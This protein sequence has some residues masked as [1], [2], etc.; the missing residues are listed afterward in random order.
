M[1]GIVGFRDPS[2]KT[3]YSI[4]TAM[5]DTLTHRGPDDAGNYI[6]RSNS[7]GL[8][9]RRLSVIDLTE[10]GR[11]PMSSRDGAVWITY[12]GEIYNYMELRSELSGKGYKF[13]SSSDTE[14]LLNA[15]L[16]WGVKCVDKLIG[17]FA[18]AVWDSRE[19]A[20]YIFR[21][22]AGVKPL[23]YYLNDGLFLFASEMKA[24]M[25]HPDFRKELDTGALSTYLRYGYIRS[26]WTI[27]ENTYK[28]SP[29]HYMRYC[30][31][32]VT[33][34]KY[35]DILDY[36]T[37]SPVNADEEEIISELETLLADSFEYRLV[38]D[39][40]VG[41]FL[42]GGIDSSLLAALLQEKTNRQQKTYTIGFYEDKY[43]EAGWARR[44][45]EHLETDH[46]EY[47]MSVNECSTIVERLPE[48]YDEP[49]ADNSGIP[50][51]FVSKLA[52]RDVKVVLS[53]DGGDEL[54]GGY[55][56]YRRV[57][58]FH[59]T[60]S[61]FPGPAQKLINLFFSYFHPEVASTLIPI[62]DAFRDKYRKFR[63]MLKASGRDSMED[64]YRFKIKKWL[65]DE[66]DDLLGKAYNRPDDTFDSLEKLCNC[67]S[68]TKMMAA[69]FKYWLPGDILAKV[70]RAT[71][72]VGLE[73]REPFLDHR[74][75]QFAAALPNRLKCGN[76]SGKYVLRKILDKYVP[77]ELM[78]RPKKGFTVPLDKWLRGDLKDLMMDNLDESKI[79]REG[80][81]NPSVVTSYVNQFIK[82]DVNVHKI[83]FLL[84]FQ[85]WRER[86]LS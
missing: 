34:E 14:V 80:I 74:L 2:G 25:A 44:I 58:E 36:Y 23:Y 10:L 31:G 30:D 45:A 39:V 85:M 81:F 46:T 9:H 26:P 63:Y 37:E 54:F 71:M 64:I 43:N 16:E 82:G 19:D 42:S 55:K 86:W 75:V 8:G 67:D 61:R 73:G 59:R 13:R 69:D 3:D 33:E 84:M 5:R 56:R 49:F 78:D 32:R 1:C 38:S 40:P 24:L 27:F 62:G 35:W 6:D 15:Y 7:V 53:A 21:D 47:Y 29:G 22:R 79:R 66:I 28:L 12:N 77:S 60:F 51:H 65:P 72:S 17:M 11:Q 57:P 83:W 18:F 76:G 41:L 70:D 52:R 48:I 20:I 50:T 4:L 68:V